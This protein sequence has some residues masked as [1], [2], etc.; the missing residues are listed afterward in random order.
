MAFTSCS[1]AS[2]FLPPRKHSA[3]PFQLTKC[4]TLAFPT[5]LT[6]RHPP[7][8]LSSNSGTCSAT[9]NSNN[10]ATS[11]S[12]KNQEKEKEVEVEVEEELPWIQEKALDLV[13]F[14]ASVTQAIPGPRVGPTSLPWILAIPLAYAS[15][16]F[17]IAFVKTVK[18][19]SSPKAKRRRMVSHTRYSLQSTVFSVSPLRLVLTFY[20]PLHFQV[21]KTPPCASR[22]MIYFRTEETKLRMKLSSKFRTRCGASFLS[23]TVTFTPSILS[24]HT[25]IAL[26]TLETFC[27]LSCLKRARLR[28]LFNDCFLL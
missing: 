7:F 19:F 12:I 26:E 3:I 2:R 4:T 22:W 25:G 13:E 23:S 11:N 21:S 14:T 18:K 28:C 17:V 6:P 15:L 27:F 10:N 8:S 24:F 16:T 9:P 5:V 20:V 1:I